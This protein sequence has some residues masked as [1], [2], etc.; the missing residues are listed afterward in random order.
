[1]TTKPRYTVRKMTSGWNGDV[2]WYVFDTVKKGRVSVHAMI[3]RDAAQ[4][5]ADELN[6]SDMVKPHAEDPRP[7]EERL[8]EARAAFQAAKGMTD[9]R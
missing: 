5:S 4:L 3:G 2:K 8:A 7:Y 1:M 6:I 9:D